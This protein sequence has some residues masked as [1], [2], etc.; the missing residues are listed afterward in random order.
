MKKLILLTAL[1][2]VSTVC[3]SQSVEIEGVSG[4]RFSGVSPI[5]DD[6]G[7]SVSGYYTHYIID[8]GA[9]GMRTLEFSIINKEVSKVS[10][11]QIELH[12]FATLNNT[13][14]NGKNF[15]ISYDDRKNKKIVFTTIDL[16]GNIVATNSI[17]ADKRRSAYSVV[18]PAAKGEGFY[19]VRPALVKNRVRGHYL[20][21]INNDLEVVWSIE[22]LTEKGYIGIANLI[23]ND[24]RVVVWRE[25]GK[26]INKLKPQIVCYDAATGETI[27]TRDGYD[28][29]STILHNQIRIDDENN[30][31]VGGAYVDGEKYKS[32]N[33]TGVYLLKLTADGEEEFYTKIVT[34]EKIQPVLKAVSKGFA[35]GSK[36]K[37]WLEDVVIDGDQIVLIS[38]MFRKNFNPKPQAFQGPRDLITGK[39]IGDM[40]YRNEQGQAP[41]VTFEI[42]DFILLKFNADGDLE[43]IKPIQKDGY[44]KLTVYHPHYGLYGMSLA[45]VVERL[46]WFDYGFTS[47]NADGE[48]FMVC[49]NNAEARK[50]Q[51]LTYELNGNFAKS[52]I[53]LRQEAKI[54]LDEGRVS[55]FKVMRNEGT[56]IAVAYYQRKLKKV[57]INIESVE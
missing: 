8:K 11:A 16:D 49:S 1:M 56:N 32:V 57:T 9:K 37:I 55:Y 19:V 4:F 33:N 53:N 2:L 17:T 10:Q 25:H 50:P 14:F 26:G 46:G 21:K 22:D 3:M 5:L 44:N 43:E 51:V 18:Y 23:N 30:I 47:T 35:I 15:L 52:E 13:V 48:K 27:F 54:N 31:L 42:M 7:E 34:K 20:E 24:D 39:W 45:A 41:K 29:E 40:S 38:E 12:K 36:D 6:K 28:G